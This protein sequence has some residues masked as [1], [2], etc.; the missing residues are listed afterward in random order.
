VVMLD[1]VEATLARELPVMYAAAR[2]VR[3]RDFNDFDR[4]ALARARSF[5]E[6]RLGAGFAR[7][8]L[9]LRE[10]DRLLE[11]MRTRFRG[12]EIKLA[13]P[14]RFVLGDEWLEDLRPSTRID[15]PGGPLFLDTDLKAVMVADRALRD[16]AS[17]A[18]LRG[19]IEVLALTTEAHEARHAAEAS[20]PASSPPPALFE[21]MAGRSSRMISW[22]DS[23]L[24][25]FL[26]E[27][28]DAP[29][30][31][32]VNLGRMMRTVYGRFARRELHF[33]ATLALL[34]QLGADPEQDPAEQ[35]AAVCA[36][37]DAQLRN[38]VA[39][40]WSRLYSLAFAAGE[41]SSR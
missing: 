32:C 34:K 30:P 18:A 27:L 2:E 25:A 1:R 24:Q 16:E 35:L 12:D 36:T 37:P 3:S 6:A 39:A 9:A 5:L 29:V 26:G 22:A 15:R 17:T 10:R 20:D 40:I 21:V 33:Y 13:V 8:A 31:G 14:E 41:R 7:T 19:A 11:E 23:E 38:K 4:T 28:H